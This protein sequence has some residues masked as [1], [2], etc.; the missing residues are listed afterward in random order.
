MEKISVILLLKYLFINDD[1]IIFYKR[2]YMGKL[3]I[4]NFKESEF[5]RYIEIYLVFLEFLCKKYGV[6]VVLLG[7]FFYVYSNYFFL[8][9]GYVLDDIYY[10]MVK[11]NLI[12]M[13]LIFK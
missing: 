9:N 11:N 7:Y 8:E 2:E 12:I 10:D 13:K 6:F 1:I 5:I 4:K 3:K